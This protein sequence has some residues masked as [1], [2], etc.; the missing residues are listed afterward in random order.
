M[1]L[2][3]RTAIVTGGGSGI[4]AALASALVAAGARV[5]VADLDEQAAVRVASA[6]NE[7]TP[8][9]ALGLEVDVSDQVANVE[10]IAA[11]EAAFG[12]VDLFFANAG[13]PGA[14]GL[15]AGPQAWAQA[16]GVNVLAHVH[17]AQILVPQWVERGEGYFVSTA[18]AAGL[19]TQLGSATYA[20]SKHG[21]VAFAE[22]LAVTYG[23]QG[24]KVSVVCPMGVDTPL[25]QGVATAGGP[26]AVLASKAVTTAG[27]VLTADEV[28]AEVLAGID[29]EQFLILP[30][31]AVLDMFRSKAADYAGW[32]G[33]MRWYK[34]TLE[35]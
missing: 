27:K 14:P 21:A 24:V 22:W 20:V 28:A 35:G 8:D 2:N 31:Q 34:R 25:L 18:S 9:A 5:V 6:L 1:E 7:T 32:L 15:D 4:G 29:R 26:D 30:H 3:G 16:I 10:L 33:G 17:A 11:T 19:L 12:P 13:V 23:E